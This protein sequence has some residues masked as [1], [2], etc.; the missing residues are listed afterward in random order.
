MIARFFNVPTVLWLTPMVQKI[1]AAGASPEC[2]GRPHYVLRLQTAHLGGS[3]HAPLTGDLRRLLEAFRVV[4]YE[5][6]VYEA[7]GQEDPQH[8]VG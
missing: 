2:P 8:R 7:L 4:L 3:L 5:A 1:K 6:A